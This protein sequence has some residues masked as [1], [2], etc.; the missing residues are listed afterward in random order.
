MDFMRDMPGKSIDLAVVDPPYGI[1][2]FEKGSLRFD[3]SEKAKNGL[4]WDIKPDKKYFKELF[5]VSKNQIIWGANNFELPT[6][7]YFLIWDKQPTVFNF[8][9]AEYAWTNIKKPAQVFRYSIQ[10]EMQNRKKE[11]GKIHP[12]QKPVA[13]YR[14]ILQNYAKPGQLILDTHSGSG[15]CAVAC[16]CEEFDFIAI[17]KDP[18]YHRDSV[19]RLNEIKSQGRL[20]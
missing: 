17:E 14:W 19:A 5:R 6:T 18:D 1:K 13:L 4:R 12:T 16:Y 9:S 2:R 10:K 11:G 3:K 15:S 8:A 20:F 7:E